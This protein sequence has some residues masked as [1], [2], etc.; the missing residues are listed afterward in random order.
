MTAGQT[1]T[2]ASAIGVVGQY[3]SGTL[4]L[5]SGQVTPLQ[6]D[7]AGNLK[8][9][10]A[11]G[12]G[13]SSSYPFST[14]PFPT[15]T[16]TPAPNTAVGIS[17]PVATPTSAPTGGVIPITCSATNGGINLAPATLGA[18]YSLVTQGQTAQAGSGLGILGVY[19]STLPTLT[20]GQAAPIQQDANGR[21]II[22]PSTL[23]TPLAT[24]PISGNVGTAAVTGF[25]ATRYATT[26]V[27]TN[28]VQGICTTACTAYDLSAVNTTAAI[29]YIQE[30]A[31][32]TGSVTL[33]TTAP[34]R[35]VLVPATGYAAD[36]IPPT[37]GDKFATAWS[38]ATTTTPTGSTACGSSVYVQ[39]DYI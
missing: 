3:Y 15:A 23:P 32:A 35:I 34:V 10:V 12:G 16:Q 13:G 18:P 20:T 27:T 1:G 9:N 36:N 28:T 21:V 31:V 37:I 38:Y 17:C 6:V 29:C 8:V 33:G 19:N 25:G 24:Q 2:S 14:V 11:V 30:F 4:S 7:S 5:T 26:T 39:A 22:S